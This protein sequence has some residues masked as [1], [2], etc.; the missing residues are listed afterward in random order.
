MSAILTAA[1]RV[2]ATRGYAAGTTNHIAER[3]GISV[4][5]LYEYFPNKDAILVALLETHLRDA[6]RVLGELVGE[7]AR[8]RSS[9]AAATRRFVAAMVELHARDPGLH[10]VLFEQAPL[11]AR[12]LANLAALEDASAR[13]LEE[14]LRRSPETTVRD[15]RLAAQLVMQTVEALTHRLVLHPPDSADTRRVSDEIA[16]LVIRYLTAP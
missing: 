14:L 9:L 5:S 6:E 3:A 2:F 7:V 4:G 11:P 10:R 16:Q 1:A 8:D 12:V 13:A 15:P